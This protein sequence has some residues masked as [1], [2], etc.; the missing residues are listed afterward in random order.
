MSH[1]FSIGQTVV[2]TP[3]AGEILRSATRGTIT[4]L[5]P[6]EVE[7]YQYLV[8]V[9]PD[10]LDRRVR[11]SQIRAVETN[12]ETETTRADIRTA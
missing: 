6:K 3:D 11:E 1:K 8:R 7:D 12:S 10:S 5:L 4:R 9:D 2:Y